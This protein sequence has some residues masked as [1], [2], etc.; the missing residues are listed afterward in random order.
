MPWLHPEMSLE[1]AHIRL[2]RGYVWEMRAFCFCL[3]GTGDCLQIER[4][5]DLLPLGP[6]PLSFLQID[7]HRPA[8][9]TIYALFGSIIH[10]FV[11]KL[12]V[13]VMESWIIN[14]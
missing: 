10:V 14:G 1:E 12:F 4:N 2:S 9:R 11:L 3:T 5:R 6:F 7:V 13:P 8:Q